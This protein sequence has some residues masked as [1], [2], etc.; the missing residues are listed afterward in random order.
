MICF[1]FARRGAS[2]QAHAAKYSYFIKD[3]A[4]TVVFAR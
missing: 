1:I 3:F 4:D 2:P